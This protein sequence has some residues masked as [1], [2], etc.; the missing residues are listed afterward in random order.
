MKTYNGAITAIALAMLVVLNGCSGEADEA[1]KLG[2]ASI[3]EM[4][5][6]HAKGWHT[7]ER[8][9]EDIAKEKGY[10]SV[11]E[12]RA[13]QENHKSVEMALAKKKEV[14]S[15]SFSD[16]KP[17]GV[18]SVTET[19]KPLVSEPPDLS[20][21]CK[22]VGDFGLEED[23]C[24]SALE[25]AAQFAYWGSK[26]GAAWAANIGRDIQLKDGLVRRGYL[27][28]EKAKVAMDNGATN[29][30]V[31]LNYGAGA[32]DA[33]TKSVARCKKYIEHVSMINR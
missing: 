19:K 14:E 16:S 5:E 25:C 23:A 20:A 32:A 1:K 3:E 4:K 28:E 2:F 17:Y 13:V 15:N 11:A 26:V 30:V 27:T 24:A 9:E 7:K 33:A 22:I 21:R 12:M 31:I 18:S 8:Y 10:N 29:A 6:I